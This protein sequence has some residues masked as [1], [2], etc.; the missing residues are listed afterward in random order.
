MGSGT[1]PG[2]PWVRSPASCAKFIT[3]GRMGLWLGPE[4]LCLRSRTKLQENCSCGCHGTCPLGQPGPA[5]KAS[6]VASPS[7]ARSPLPAKQLCQLWPATSTRR[8]SISPG[9]NDTCFAKSSGESA[10]TCLANG[11]CFIDVLSPFSPTWRVARWGRASGR[12]IGAKTGPQKSGTVPCFQ[13]ETT[14]AHVTS[15]GKAPT[16]EWSNL[17]RVASPSSVSASSPVGGD[18]VSTTKGG[19]EH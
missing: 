7:K 9:H 18:R 4:A 11:R 10:C 6:H 15:L 8:A 5:E 14:A 13:E 19:C 2:W 12:G 17:G 1:Q 3:G 16:Y